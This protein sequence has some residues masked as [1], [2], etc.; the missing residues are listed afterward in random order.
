[1]AAGATLS[2]V[3]SSGAEQSGEQIRSDSAGN[4]PQ[5]GAV[6]ID[7]SAGRNGDRQF[8]DC[9]P[10]RQRPAGGDGRGADDDCTADGCALGC[11]GLGCGMEVA[12]GAGAGDVGVDD[13]FCLM[14]S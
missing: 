9:D 3:F 2:V 8:A 13:T 14:S 10:S 1:M 6:Q 7:T 11:G 4:W 5:L 12:C